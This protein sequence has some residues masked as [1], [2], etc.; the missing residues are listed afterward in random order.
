MTLVVF[1]ILSILGLAVMAQIPNTTVGF[2]NAPSC[3][4]VQCDIYHTCVM[5]A[6]HDED[7]CFAACCPDCSS[8]VCANCRCPY[9]VLTV[10]NELPVR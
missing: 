3:Q 6:C 7:S 5:M 1:F 10:P 8:G 2:Q 9:C 4:F